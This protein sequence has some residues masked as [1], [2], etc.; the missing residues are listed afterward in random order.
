MVYNTDDWV[1][2]KGNMVD[3]PVPEAVNSIGYWFKPW[4]FTH[5]AKFLETGADIECVAAAA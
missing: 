4:F 5:V 3:T 2:M 1:V